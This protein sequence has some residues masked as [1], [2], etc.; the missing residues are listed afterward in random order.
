MSLKDRVDGYMA[1]IER[2]EPDI[3]AIDA[4][5]AYAS[6]AISLKRIADGLEEIT[7]HF[8][9]IAFSLDQICKVGDEYSHPDPDPG[10]EVPY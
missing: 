2:L 10:E 8:P 3:H 6:I 1:T 9:M 5:A 7:K 4:A